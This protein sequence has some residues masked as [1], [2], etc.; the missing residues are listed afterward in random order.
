MALCRLQSSFPKLRAIVL[1]GATLAFVSGCS[2]ARLTSSPSNPRY[3]S[4]GAS[5]P[6]GGGKA[7]VGKPHFT[8]GRWYYPAKDPSYN[9]VGLASW[10]GEKFHGRKTANGEIYDVNRLTVA[11]PT[12]PL[13]SYLE[14]TNLENGR[15]LIL[16]ANDRGP[17]IA[18]RLVDVSERAARLLG[19]HRQGLV[20]VRVRYLRAAPLNGDD[21]HEEQF[22][23]QQRQNPMPQLR[24][25]P[26]TLWTCQRRL[27]SDPGLGDV[28]V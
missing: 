27:E 25:P 12:L 4:V 21:Y 5:T 3:Y 15:R 22:A 2:S 8:N 6:K 19:F 11:H 17:F 16:R 7:F 10:Y 26:R 24:G 20:K 9:R 23:L 14:V 1:L 28:A 18:G 13:P